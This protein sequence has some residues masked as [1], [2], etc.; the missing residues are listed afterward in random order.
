MKTYTVKLIYKY[1]VEVQV[2]ADSPLEAKQEAFMSGD[3]V[4]NYDDALLDCE[5][6]DEIENEE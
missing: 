3:A 2:K 1:S 5:I 6:I 4:H